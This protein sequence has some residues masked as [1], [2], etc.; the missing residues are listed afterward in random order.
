MTRPGVL[1]AVCPGATRERLAVEAELARRE[2]RCVA[3]PAE[4]DLL[5]IV[6][7]R[8]AEESG[9]V[10]NLWQAM[11]APKSW[12]TLT[13][14]EQVTE[15]LDRGLTELR[16]G[17]PPRPVG[18]TVGAPVRGQGT[19]E[20]AGGP[21]TAQSG[22]HH[23]H[24]QPHEH[25]QHDADGDHI[26]PE[27][28]AA[29]GDHES[30]AGHEM[31]GG[32]HGHAG[33]EMGGV[34]DGLPMADRADDRD[35]LRLDQLHVPLGPGLVDWPAGLILRLT[36]QG[37]IVQQ[38]GID[39]LVPATPRPSFWNEPWL[40]AVAGERVTR[41]DAAR[42][43][44]AAHLDSL[45]RFFAVAGWADMAARARHVRDRALAGADAAEL[46]A[47]VRPLIRKAER[48]RTLR[49]L[50]AGLGPLP[51]EHARHLR[52]TGPA[53]RADGDAYSRMLVWLDAV[54]RST[55]ACDDSGLLG[56]AEAVGPRG[57]I[58]GQAPPSRALLDALPGLLEGAEF[59]C[60]RIIVASLDPDLDELARVPAAGAPHD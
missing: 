34:V 49:W 11:P 6:G 28:H 26:S 57:Q 5:V 44:C 15:T 30:H 13:S 2:W 25:S 50:T 60:A 56:E 54:G 45:G 31:N 36:L 22:E 16:H 19:G 20:P 17:E 53:Q 35:G 42:R 51:A 29:H 37:D 59:A 12:V 4:A 7:D 10:A 27:R 46:S 9:W 21:T 58:D 24:E 3:V 39:S 1:L 52:V 14:T 48:S 38:T 47:L 8:D 41:G 23:H 55:A 33:H 43:L 32:H 40:R 18:E